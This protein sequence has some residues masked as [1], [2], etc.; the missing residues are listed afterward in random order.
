MS[1]PSQLS[2]AVALAAA[3]AWPAGTAYSTGVLTPKQAALQGVV[4]TA[5][6]R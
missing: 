6:V 2:V 5:K 3:A 4:A 1:R